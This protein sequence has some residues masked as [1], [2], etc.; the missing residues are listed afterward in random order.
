[1][2]DEATSG[3]PRLKEFTHNTKK[4]ELVT[5]QDIASARAEVAT[6]VAPYLYELTDKASS[7]ILDLEAKEFELIQ[8]LEVERKEHNARMQQQT[9]VKSGI[10]NK[11]KLQSLTR[12]KEELSRSVTELDEVLDQKREEF[13]QF[14]KRAE[15]IGS[16]AESTSVKRQK[17]GHVHRELS[18]QVEEKQK[19]VARRAE[20]LKA[21]QQR[22]ED[23]RRSIGERRAKAESRMSNKSEAETPFDPTKPWTKYYQHYKRLE[24]ALQT[25]FKVDGHDK[26]VYEEA[27]SRITAACIRDLDV[28]QAKTDVE[29]SKLVQ[30][31]GKMVSQMRNLC[32]LLFPVDNIG[33]TMVRVLELL[34]E[35]TKNEVVYA[36]LV[37]TEFP[38]EEE[39][40]HNLSRVI[41]TLKRMG[42]IEVVEVENEEEQGG[43]PGRS[44]KQLVLRINFED[45]Y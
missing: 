3:Y 37:Q 14:H 9:A 11:R 24:D 40:R 7:M 23:K 35:S 30:D 15:S 42:L 28:Q 36:D 22:I 25:T 29:L 20:A 17:R 13:R 41:T 18:K 45:G 31:K 32:R 39:R 2:L 1:M 12:R 10:S 44:E 4:A 19:E 38:P 16:Q 21:L 33:Q 8:R 27:F 6:K 34:A 43:E 5:E 26:S